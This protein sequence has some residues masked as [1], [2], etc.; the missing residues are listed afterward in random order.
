M[1]HTRSDLRPIPTY[2]V[3]PP[4]HKGD[5]VEDHFY[6]KFVEENPEVS[7]DYIAISW[8]TLYCQQ[9]DP[10]IQ[11]FLNSLDKTK[12]YFTVCQHDDAPRHNLPPNTLI[13]SLSQSHRNPKNLNPIPIPA[14]CSPI[15]FSTDDCER[16][17]FASFVGSITHPMRIELYNTCKNE[18]NYYFSGQQW[19]PSIPDFKLQEFISITK[20]SKFALCPRGYG[21][22]SFRLYESMQI[23]AV[24][25]YISDD[26][27]L[28]WSDELD[29]NEFCVIVDFKNLN[30][31]N[32]IL[33]SYSEEK[34]KQM[35]KKAKEVYSNYFT[36]DATYKNIIKRLK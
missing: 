31:L 23:G 25:V 26:F 32:S 8:T 13:F 19:N 14:T 1:I 21:N 3:Y 36:L 15:P 4:Y 12:K 7:R 17:V 29:W 35:A 16:D 27:F 9:Q 34:I 10:G 20:R 5:Y 2:P 24:P 30:S 22:T 33:S 11:E 18:T 28:P 6:K